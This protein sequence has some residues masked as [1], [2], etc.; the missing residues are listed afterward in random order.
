MPTPQEIK[1][2]ARGFGQRRFLIRDRIYAPEPQTAALRLLYNEY[3]ERPAINPD[4]PQP[5]RRGPSRAPV[6]TG[7]PAPAPPGPQTIFPGLRPRETRETG[8]LSA[9]GVILAGPTNSSPNLPGGSFF[10]SPAIGAASTRVTIGGRLWAPAIVNHV[11]YWANVTTP[12]GNTNI[13]LLIK[14]S[15]DADTTG[16]LDTSGDNLEFLNAQSSNLLEPFNIWTHHH[17]NFLIP[18]N[19]KFIKFAWQNFTAG[20]VDVYA[21]VD[22]RYLLPA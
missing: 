10:S 21:I 16:G 17:P 7:Q 2:G 12:A 5:G 1:P 9:P 11:A 6:T 4:F 19:N 8:A 20:T 14:F 13:A 18:T 15:D 3:P 22:L